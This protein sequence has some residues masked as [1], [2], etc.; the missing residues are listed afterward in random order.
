MNIQEVI[1]TI[2]YWDST[3]LR[4]EVNHFADELILSCEEGTFQFTGCNQ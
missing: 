3:L 2:H 1:Q 4:L